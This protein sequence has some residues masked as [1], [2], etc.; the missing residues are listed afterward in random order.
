MSKKEYY[1]IIGWYQVADFLSISYR[2][3][4]RKLLASHTSFEVTV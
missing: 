3:F 2:I 1:D 4:G